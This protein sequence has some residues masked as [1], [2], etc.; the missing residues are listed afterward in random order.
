LKVISWTVCFEPK[1]FVTR[2]VIAIVNT[3][4]DPFSS[5]T[6]EESRKQKAEQV[7]PSPTYHTWNQTAQWRASHSNRTD[8]SI[9]NCLDYML[10]IS[11]LHQINKKFSIT[12]KNINDVHHMLSF[13]SLSTFLSC[14]SFLFLYNKIIGDYN[15]TNFY[16]VNFQGV[17]VT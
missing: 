8:I 6:I 15:L 9:K 11:L 3:I 12:W 13:P 1:Y 17:I 16:S 2:M 10:F 4:E 7:I 5:N 14:L